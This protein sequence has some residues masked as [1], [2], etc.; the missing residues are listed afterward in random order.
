[1]PSE[2]P[3]L[4]IKA[5]KTDS[6]KTQQIRIIMR[7]SLLVWIQFSF[8]HKIFRDG[9]ILAAIN[10]GGSGEAEHPST[11]CWEKKCTFLAER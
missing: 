10:D 2:F 11:P 9:D 1:M 3:W 8:W 6:K 7:Q 4:K 5:M